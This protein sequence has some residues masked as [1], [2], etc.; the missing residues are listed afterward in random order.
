M[1]AATQWCELP[2]RSVCISNVILFSIG[3]IY[4]T[5]SNKSH[6]ECKTTR[7]LDLLASCLFSIGPGQWTRFAIN[8][9]CTLGKVAERRW[10][11]SDWLSVTSGMINEI[12]D[13]HIYLSAVCHDMVSANAI[14][15][16]SRAS[17]IKVIY[18]IWHCPRSVISSFR[19]WSA[20]F[21]C[22]AI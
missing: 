2:V 19:F 18:N 17:H 14:L 20:D 13:L 12:M 5:N 8:G 16:C 4:Q 21:M 9:K 1:V 3:L 6:I 11:W 10:R 15:I 7:I 22:A